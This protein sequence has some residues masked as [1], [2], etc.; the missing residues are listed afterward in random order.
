MLSGTV[1]LNPAV[2]PRVESSFI[3]ELRRA[4][5][6]GFTA[7]EV[8]QA[9]KAYEESRMVGRSTDGALLNLIATHEQLDRP[10]SWDAE[11]E[12]KI[13]A[14]T[15]DQINAVFRKHIDPSSLSIVKAG[16]FKAAG[17]FR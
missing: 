3:E 17:V 15:V 7:A 4:Y 5:Q 1:S 12:R 16:D 6:N 9:K 2:G 8:A 14:L 13:Q 11:V 10:L